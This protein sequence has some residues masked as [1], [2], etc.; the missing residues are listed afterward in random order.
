MAVILVR[1]GRV[2][3]TT[4]DLNAK[5]NAF[6]Q[7]LRERFATNPIGRIVSLAP[8]RCRQTVEPLAG[9]TAVEIETAGSVQ[10]LISAIKQGDWS[11]TDLVITFQAAVMSDLF[12]F[13]GL[14]LP[15][16]RDDAYGTVWIYDKA[17][18]SVTVIDTGHR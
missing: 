11:S 1:H 14:M 13:L 6:A 8:A 9:S 7:A 12:S 16:T 17:T 2:D 5:G 4:M 3:Y 10:G 18:G 15:A